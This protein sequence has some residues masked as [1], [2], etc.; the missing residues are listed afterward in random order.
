MKKI[1]LNHLLQK[2]GNELFVMPS[3]TNQHTKEDL[4]KIQKDAAENAK[5]SQKLPPT[6]SFNSLD[7][8]QLFRQR[9]SKRSNPPSTPNRPSIPNPPSTTSDANNINLTD[10]VLYGQEEFDKNQKLVQSPPPK[11]NKPNTYK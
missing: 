9:L 6:T 7:N 1:F 2:Q 8:N 11:K 3:E 5:E 4:E 10:L